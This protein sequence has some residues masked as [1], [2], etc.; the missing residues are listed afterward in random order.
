MGR[1]VYGNCVK[2]TEVATCSAL[3]L[4]WLEATFYQQ[5]FAQFPAQDFTALGLTQQEITDLTNIGATEQAHVQLLQ[6]AIA[7]AGVKPV[8]PCQYNFGFTDAAGMV[9]TA[10]VL[11]S[12]G[13]SA[14]LGGGPL[15]VDKSILGTAASILTI[16]ARHQ[17]FIRAAT[18]IAAVP[19][20][21]DTALSPKQVFS[22]AAPFITSCPEGS[23]LILTAFP[24]LTMAGGA[25][26]NAV[27][28]GA[29]LQLQ[30]DAASQATFCA[31]TSGGIAGGTAFSAFDQAN[32][33]VV[34]QNLAGVVYVNLA[35][36][37]P[38]TG[39]ITDDIIVAGPMVMQVS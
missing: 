30:S 24:T 6:S 13:I 39:Q 34:P 9:A 10:S 18:K 20:P 16:E 15:I 2:L 38:L 8:Q 35:T 7:Q 36:A 25:S 14:Y 26:A 1:G 33:C 5:G 12:V 32:G 21:F 28:A 22:L 27:Q 17:T 31:F 37:G 19:Q 11:E 29:Q 4:E 3:T 23:N